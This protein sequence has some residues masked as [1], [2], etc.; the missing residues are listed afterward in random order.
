MGPSQTQVRRGIVSRGIV[1][2]QSDGVSGS[3]FRFGSFIVDR[4]RYRVQQGETL[5]ELTPKLLDLL[6]YLLDHA[7]ELVTKEQLLDA[8]WPDANVTDNALAQAVSELREALGDEPTA[9]QY[10]KTVARR[11]YRFIAPVVVVHAQAGG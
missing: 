10:I 11:G 2:L 4:T 7:G 3:D 5:L 9:A 8:L 6:L 1:R